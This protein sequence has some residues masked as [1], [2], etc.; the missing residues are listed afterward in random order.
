MWKIIGEKNQNVVK[1]T[2]IRTIK[3]IFFHTLTGDKNI[4]L[5]YHKNCQFVV[6]KDYSCVNIY[7]ITFG[8]HRV[9]QKNLENFLLQRPL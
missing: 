2:S 9:F 4:R 1:K 5:I 3:I 6:Q 8:F 7:R